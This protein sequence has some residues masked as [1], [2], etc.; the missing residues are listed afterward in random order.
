M[1]LLCESKKRTPWDLE[2]AQLCITLWATTCVTHRRFGF[3]Y[4]I[5][6]CK[7]QTGQ[8]WLFYLQ[9]GDFCHT[10]CSRPITALFT[11]L[12]NMSVYTIIN[13]CQ[14]CCLLSSR[15]N[16]PNPVPQCKTFTW[17]GSLVCVMHGGKCFLLSN[18]Q[19]ISWQIFL[20]DL[21]ILTFADWFSLTQWLWQRSRFVMN[22]YQ[23]Q[24]R[25]WR[26][27]KVTASCFLCRVYLWGVDVK[28]DAL[29]KVPGFL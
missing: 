28:K 15:N 29:N 19:L 27:H 1:K 6:P 16:K 8:L 20:L 11:A 21:I 18:L 7:Q 12:N 4:L 26:S 9:K 23:S 14:P 2:N 25:R 17:L 22:S 5:L 24:A 13:N 3:C 10:E